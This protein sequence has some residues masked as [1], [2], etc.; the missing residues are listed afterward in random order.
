VEKNL[1][2]RLDTCTPLW[3]QRSMS[4]RLASWGI[5]LGEN[6]LESVIVVSSALMIACFVRS[7]ADLH[8]TRERL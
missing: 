8:E 2:K 3:T 1:A 6:R 4:T 7:Q 5:E